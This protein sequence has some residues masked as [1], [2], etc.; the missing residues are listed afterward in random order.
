MLRERLGRKN[1]VLG[2]GRSTSDSID[3]FDSMVGRNRIKLSWLYNPSVRETRSG[4]RFRTSFI[5]QF[6]GRFK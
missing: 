6:G 5:T 4:K 2:S 3:G 1:E